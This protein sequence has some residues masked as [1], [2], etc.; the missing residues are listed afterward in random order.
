MAM[1]NVVLK[2][3]W[4]SVKKSGSY[5]CL[6]RLGGKSLASWAL[7]K[8]AVL[9]YRLVKVNSTITRPATSRY[10]EI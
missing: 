6:C 7:L 5:G 2:V 1:V 9:K 4:V 8:G 3:E 10:H